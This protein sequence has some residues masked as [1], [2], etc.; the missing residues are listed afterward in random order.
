M[1][2]NT[3]YGKGNASESPPSKTKVIVVGAGFAGMT[4]CIEC[5]LRGMEA[6]LIEKYTN[7]AQYGDII[8]FFANAGRIIAAWDDGKISRQLLDVCIVKAKYMQ[9]LK[10][11]GELVYKDPWY[12]KPEH[13]HYQFAGQRGTMWQIFRDYAER[14]GVHFMFGRGVV[15][16][17]EEPH[18]A[19]VVLSDGTKIMGDC[20]VAAD[21]PKSLARRKVLGLADVKTNSG[22]AIYRSYFSV[23]DEFRKEPLLQN[24][25]SRDEDMIKIWIGPQ[26]HM[27]AYSWMQGTQIVWVLTHQVN[28]F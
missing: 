24:Y 15:D 17:I 25:L 6:V 26:S 20:V 21:G 11:T 5:R 23:T 4:T 2:D 22:F 18:A 27:L 8:D 3:Q 28:L 10:H 1:A 14:L 19:G 12:L 16:Y 9:M 7:S 13:Y